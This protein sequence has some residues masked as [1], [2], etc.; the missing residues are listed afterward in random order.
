MMHDATAEQVEKLEKRLN[1]EIKQRQD[2]TKVL[3]SV[4]IDE[5][6]GDYF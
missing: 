4:L 5:I 1:F 2:T 6:V 3:Q